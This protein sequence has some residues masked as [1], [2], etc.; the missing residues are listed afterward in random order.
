MTKNGL[1]RDGAQKSMPDVLS[2]AVWKEVTSLL[3][4]DLEG[5]Q[6]CHPRGLGTVQ[7]CDTTHG[8]DIATHHSPYCPWPGRVM[9][10]EVTLASDHGIV[11]QSA[12]QTPLCGS[13][14]LSPS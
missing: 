3:Q 7:P 9:R 8:G 10:P 1:C 4:A 13:K 14:P 5:L 12:E 11:E 2:E 6:L